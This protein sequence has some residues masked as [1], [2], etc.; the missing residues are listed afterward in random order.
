MKS[1]SFNKFTKWKRSAKAAGS[2]C[3]Y[4]HSAL[5][6]TGHLETQQ[7]ISDLPI[8]QM[9]ILVCQEI[10]FMGTSFDLATQMLF[11]VRSTTTWA[12][13]KRGIQ[14]HFPPGTYSKLL[15]Q[16]C[17]PL[18]VVLVVEMS[19]LLSKLESCL[20]CPHLRVKRHTDRRLVALSLITFFRTTAMFAYG[21]CYR[22]SWRMASL[23]SHSEQGGLGYV[24][25]II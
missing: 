6:Y 2:G 16:N 4:C 19:S 18:D 3:Q 22:S 17:M 20:A 7:M 21:M 24:G 5:F 1:S 13:W 9:K 14:M 25:G 12:K 8:G 15:V 23:I 10:D 11:L